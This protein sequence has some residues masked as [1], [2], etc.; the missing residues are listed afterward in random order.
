MK[1]KLIVSIGLALFLPAQVFA[2]EIVGGKLISH[3]EINTGKVKFNFQD[4]KIDKKL[5]PKKNNNLNSQSDSTEQHIG[6]SSHSLMQ[7]AYSMGGGWIHLSG[8]HELF[9]INSSSL[10]TTY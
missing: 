3:K 6:A 1:T 7:E 2:M 5:F 4:L 9:V 8:A 10:P